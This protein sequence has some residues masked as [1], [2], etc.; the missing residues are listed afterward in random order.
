MN[1]PTDEY[2]QAVT[3]L[4]PLDVRDVGVG[5]QART[6]TAES[7]T[8]ITGAAG[9]GREVRLA[10]SP[11][12]NKTGSRIGSFWRSERNRV[13]ALDH[14]R[15]ERPDT[16][17]PEITS[18]T[19][20]NGSAA[21]VIKNPLFNMEALF[22]T[23]SGVKDYVMVLTD[24]SGNSLYAWIA[25]VAASGDSYTF[26]VYNTPTGTTQNWVGT[27]ASFDSTVLGKVRY[28]IFRYDTSFAWVTGTVLTQ[29]VEFNPTMTATEQIRLMSN[30]DY[31]INYKTGLVRYKKATT[32]TSDTCGY[33]SVTSEVLSGSV[34]PS[35][36]SS[37]SAPTI[38]SYQQVAINLAAGANQVL[39]ASAAG[40]QIWVYGYQFTVNA[41]GTVSF[42]DEDDTALSGIMPFATNGGASVAP[43]GSFAMPIWKLA[44][45][46]DLEVDV[47]TS[48]LD[49]WLVYAIVSV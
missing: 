49:G 32:G 38:D 1:Y 23:P 47:V 46:K 44:T 29:E 26:T 13:D 18:I 19:E 15:Y 42:Q 30:G 21:I 20:T 25:G 41:A 37:V 24:S 2:G 27:I 4:N 22:E 31:A 40:K 10:K 16:G 17:T 35:T 7:V 9:F 14:K 3:P 8:F 36:P 45:D 48:E 11:V 28:E 33:T 39:V 43:S 34:S 12:L 6:V 5:S